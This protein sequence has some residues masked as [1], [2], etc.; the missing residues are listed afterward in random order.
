MAWP[1]AERAG[2]IA[3]ALD[4]CT[5]ADARLN[6]ASSFDGLMIQS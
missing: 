6:L 1:E 3:H 2:P 4:P 5:S